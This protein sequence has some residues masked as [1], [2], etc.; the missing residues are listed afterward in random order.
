MAAIDAEH[1]L[2]DIPEDLDQTAAQG[3][4]V[5]ATAEPAS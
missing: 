3:D 4:A 2:D 5:Q 1:Y